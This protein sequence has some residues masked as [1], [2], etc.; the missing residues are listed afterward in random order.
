MSLTKILHNLVSGDVPDSPEDHVT[1]LVKVTHQSQETDEEV[2]IVKRGDIQ[3]TCDAFAG[4]EDAVE[5]TIFQRI[6]HAKQEPVAADPI[7][8][9]AVMLT[10]A[11]LKALKL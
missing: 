2:V 1:L 11:A 9:Q 8:N 5:V 6:Y 7:T 3:K 4:A 10:D